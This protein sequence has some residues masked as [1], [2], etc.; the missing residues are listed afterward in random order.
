M[1]SEEIVA[2]LVYGF[3]LPEVQKQYVREKGECTDILS[4]LFIRLSFNF[5]NTPILLSS[6]HHRL[7]VVL[8]LIQLLKGL[9]KDQSAA[10][11]TEFEDTDRLKII[12]RSKTGMHLVPILIQSVR[13]EDNEKGRNG[14]GKGW[15]ENSRKNTEQFEICR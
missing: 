15:S 13:R 2:E 8:H 7:I 3:L 14:R 1:Q 11:R 4:V 10:I 12:K 6:N 5:A 9:Y